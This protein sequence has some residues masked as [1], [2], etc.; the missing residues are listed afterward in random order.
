MKRLLRSV[1]DFGDGR[2]SEENRTTNFSRLQAAVDGGLVWR[3]PED[4]KVFGYLRAF[5]NANLALPSA[6]VVQD[7][8]HRLGV[9]PGT[10]LGPVDDGFGDIEVLD[11]IGVIQAAEVHTRTNYAHILEEIFEEQRRIDMLALL[12]EGQEIASRGLKIR[13]G[14][15]E[16]RLHGNRDAA[17]YLSARLWDHVHNDI[18]IKTAGD[19]GVEGRD[20]YRDYLDREAEPSSAWGV[21]T[22][23]GVLDSTFHGLRPG[24]LW[25]HAGFAGHLKSTFGMTWAYNARTIY[26]RNVLYVSLEMPYEQVRDLLVVQHTAALKY[27]SRGLHPLDYQKVQQGALT[28]EEKAFFEEA[29]EDWDQNEEHCQFHIWCP[30]RDVTVDDIRVHAET[31]ERKMDVGLIVIDHAG[32]V[33]AKRRSSSFG[34]EQNSIFRDSKKL[35]LQYRHREAKEG[36]GVPVLLLAQINREGL[37]AAEKEGGI[38]S[39]RSIAWAHEA[40]RSSDVLTATYL[41]DAHRANETTLMTCLK[42]R[43]TAHFAPTTL[44]VRFGCRRIENPALDEDDFGTDDEDWSLEDV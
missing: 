36:I 9:P 26:R 35:A 17:E 23:I 38:L 39:P 15:K 25:V 3:H 14:R 37:K 7:Y 19:I 44:R 31:L 28:A 21:A 20:A 34:V 1:L 30:D 18:P 5:Y 11:R 41:D 29:C 42:S 22:G 12:K 8:F 2:I 40:E 33:S 10:A 43:D 16:V 6:A 27:A 24:R 32:L 13:E 4:E